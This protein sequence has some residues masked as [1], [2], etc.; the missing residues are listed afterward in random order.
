MTERNSSYGNLSILGRFSKRF[1]R[2]VKS[3]NNLAENENNLT[4]PT[5]S[6]LDKRKS[7]ISSLTLDPVIIQES[8]IAPNPF[9][10]M[11]LGGAMG[12]DGDMG[13]D[14]AFSNS[15]DS[16]DDSSDDDSSDYSSDDSSDDSSDYFSNDSELVIIPTIS[17]EIR[18]MSRVFSDKIIERRSRMIFNGIIR[19]VPWESMM[20]DIRIQERSLGNVI[21]TSS[22][23]H[24]NVLIKR[25]KRQYQCLR[26]NYLVQNEKRN[27]IRQYFIKIFILFFFF[28]VSKRL[29]QN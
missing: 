14:G 22:Q 5:N 2:K 13:L 20:K 11:G 9:I 26:I 19:Q 7:I 25:I 15:D 29:I 24:E 21:T 18:E 27:D 10:A 17:D 23:Y 16:S 6:Y 28:F 4:E 8:F 12:L 1:G 3:F